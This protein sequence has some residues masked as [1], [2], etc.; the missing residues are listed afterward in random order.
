METIRVRYEKE[1]IMTLYKKIAL[2][3]S[4]IIILMLSTVMY[5]N[6]TTAKQNMLDSLYETT[7][8]NIASISTRLEKAGRSE[9]YITSVID[10]V[11]DG[12]YYE[13]I[14]YKLSDDSYAYKQAISKSSEGIPSW[15]ISLISI[16]AQKVSVDVSSGWENLGRLSVVGDRSVVYKTL[17][18]MFLNTLILFFFFVSVSLLILA[19]ML[20][21]LLKPLK[22]IQTQAE[23]IIDSKFLI[24]DT[25]PSTKEFKNVALA[26]N[27]MVTRVE[28]IFTK[29]NNAASKNKE[30]L[31]QDS[32]TKLFNRRYL[33]LKLT[34]LLE[35]ESEI[36]GGTCVL[37]SLDSIEQVNKL[38]GQIKT[39]KLLRDFANILN[40]ETEYCE[41][42]IL[43]RVNEKE[44]TLILPS[45]SAESTLGMLNEIEKQFDILLNEN[46]IDRR[47]LKTSYGVYA[48]ES[49]EH[50]SELLTKTDNA[51]LQAQADEVQNIALYEESQTKR[52]LTKRQWH[53]IL[54]ETLQEKSISLKFWTV[55]N[56]KST[57]LEHKVMTYTIVNQGKEYLFGDFIAA[58]TNFELV[59]KLTLLAIMELF[60][61]E[62]RELEGKSCSM[63]LSSQF[64]KDK[65]TYSILETLFKKQAKKLNFAMIFEVSNS[66]ALHNQTLLLSYVNLFKKY[67][68]AFGINTFTSESASLAY[69]QES[70]P[71]F[72]KADSRFL[73]DQT[74]ESM[75]ALQGVTD[76]LG[77]EIIATFVRDE[78]ETQALQEK[79]IS[80]IQGPAT[81]KYN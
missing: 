79:S 26:M 58:A 53:Q 66:F 36:G 21:F 14:K 44:F 7:V 80:I 11:F 75:D 60:T 27:S 29:A 3:V 74:K 13:L 35:S 51:L 69:L 15:F 5:I 22:E 32:V 23:A 39:N 24:L 78:K 10:S 52:A 48:F 43:T 72:I 59:S 76:S 50:I 63:R 65:E 31:Y 18:G 1:K 16:D 28:E 77:I 9:A 8:N 30:L 55:Y 4:S 73:L 34:E 2:L 33:M 71:R 20:H 49:S 81:D 12:G 42:K 45:I 19:V 6:Y 67:G 57:L 54:E 70:H 56:L 17:Y 37:V 41:E 46:E 25:L 40:I 47:I 68:F 64:L 61:Q 62:Q 38:R